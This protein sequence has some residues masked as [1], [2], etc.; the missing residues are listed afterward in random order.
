MRL[1]IALEFPEEAK[2]GIEQIQE[3]ESQR[4]IGWR[5]T[6]RD[7]LHLTMKFLGEVDE[8]QAARA[9]KLLEDV[10]AVGA[11]TLGLGGFRYLPDARRA[12]VLALELSGDLERLQALR[13]QIER[14]FESKGFERER[15]PFFPHVTIAR[16]NERERHLRADLYF[17]RPWQGVFVATELSLIQSHLNAK[18]AS[19]ET[20]G[21]FSFA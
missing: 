3:A 5:W 12:R 10:A 4:E 2:R 14:T 11:C 15:R 13:E 9:A 8:A 18:G 19:Y 6:G 20:L 16:R 7:Q 1:F 21:R 17:E